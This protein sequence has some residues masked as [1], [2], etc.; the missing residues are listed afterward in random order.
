MKGNI[1]YF[2]RNVRVGLDLE[3]QGSR[4]AQRQVYGWRVCPVCLALV[5]RSKSLMEKESSRPHITYTMRK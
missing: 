4:E 2:A 1:S 5:L 3:I